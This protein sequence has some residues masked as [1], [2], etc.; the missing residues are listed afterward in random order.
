MSRWKKEDERFCGWGWGLY[1]AWTISPAEGERA[2][3]TSPHSHNK[4]ERHGPRPIPTHRRRANYESH[5]TFTISQGR[6]LPGEQR[7]RSVQIVTTT[8]TFSFRSPENMNRLWA[9]FLSGANV[10]EEDDDYT[11]GECRRPRCYTM[12][13]KKWPQMTE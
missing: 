2:G 6:G 13:P 5:R 9:V 4:H 3:G 7:I 11:H 10:T 12:L 1:P 8:R